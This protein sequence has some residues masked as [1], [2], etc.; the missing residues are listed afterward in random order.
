L[1]R[2]HEA[3][4]AEVAQRRR[5]EEQLRRANRALLA[6][7]RCS[8]ARVR[9]RDE[10]ALLQEVCRIIVEVAGYRLCWVGYA[11][12]DEARTVRPVAQAGYEAGYLQTVR[13]TW[14]DTERGRGPTGTAARTGRPSVFR[15][16]ATDPRFA[17]WRA[18]ALAR[19]YGSVLG[20]PLHADS[21][22][23]GALTVYAAEAA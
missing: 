3:L 21:T 12:Q 16:A 1:A 22:R 6:L 9:T 5:T 11:E 8:Q 10:A 17:P 2:T 20:L 13:V 7:R 18:E 14:A 19:G 4:R 23:L 15:E